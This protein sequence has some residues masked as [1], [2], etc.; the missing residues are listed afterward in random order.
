MK[1][2]LNVDDA[3]PGFDIGSKPKGG[4]KS[5]EMKMKRGCSEFHNIIT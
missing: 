5:E 1:L 4:W 2:D 3:L